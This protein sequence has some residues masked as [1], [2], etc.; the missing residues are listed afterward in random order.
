MSYKRPSRIRTNNGWRRPEVP[1]SEMGFLFRADRAEATNDWVLRCLAFEGDFARGFDWPIDTDGHIQAPASGVDTNERGI[2]CWFSPLVSWPQFEILR[3]DPPD[4]EMFVAP[5]LA[6]SF[7]HC[8]NVPLVREPISP[9]L[10]TKRERKYGWTPDAWHTLRIEP[11]RMQLNAAGAEGVGGLKRALHIMRGH[12]KDYREGRGL[13]GKQHGIWWWDF[14][15][16]NS[17][18]RHQYNI[19]P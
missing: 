8:K 12:F 1:P 11:M 14:P 6:I 17:P 16:S 2:Q 13:F 3:N 4:L 5:F 9:K 15:L 18:H 19:R 10:K 7:C